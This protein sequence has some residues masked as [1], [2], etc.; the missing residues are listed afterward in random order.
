MD[1][2][3][4]LHAGSAEELAR[5]GCRV[6]TG[7]GHAIAVFAHEG[8][9]YALDNRCPHMGFPLA[10]GTVQEGLLICHWHHARFDLASGDT[11]DLF[12]GNT[13]RFETLTE[14]GEVYVAMVPAGGQ[15]ERWNRRMDEALEHDGPVGDCA[16][17]YRDDG[18]R[19]G[20]SGRRCGRARSSASATPQAAGTRA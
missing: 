16:L 3:H 9:F 4:W 13:P 8:R 19:D 20:L 6:I 15:A 2:R 10:Q 5:Q 17:D 11:F 1:A 12:A 18:R 14:D 7:A